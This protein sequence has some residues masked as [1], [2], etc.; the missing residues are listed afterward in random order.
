MP[1]RIFKFRENI[2]LRIFSSKVFV[3]KLLRVLSF[4]VF[5]AVIASGVYFYGFPQTEHS[6][7]FDQRIIKYSLI[8]FSVRFLIYVFYDFHPVDFIKNNRVEGI[9]LL[10][11]VIYML[12]PGFFNSLIFKS[13]FNDITERHSHI[14]FQIYF[15]SI[16]VV[17]LGKSGPKFSALNLSPASALILSFIILIGAGAGLLMLPEMTTAG[18]ISFINALFTSTSASC[19][20]GLIVV[21]TA[22]FFTFKGKLIIMLLIQLGGI[23]IISFATFFVTFSRAH[24]NIK[25][26]SFIKDF[27]SADRLSDTK[28]LLR[29]IVLFSL[30]SEGI[31]TAL[32]FFSWGNV[33][34]GSWKAQFFHS[35]FHAVSAFNNAGFSTFTNNLYQ[36]GIRDLYAVQVVVILLIFFGG[37]GFMSMEDIFSWSR[38][39]ERRKMPWKRLNIST[40]VTLYMSLFLIAFGAIIF[41]LVERNTHIYGS[42]NAFQIGITSVFQ[43]V[44]TRTAGFNTVDISALKAPVLILF[45]FLMFVGAGSGSTGGGIK[46]TTFAVIVKSAL[47]TIKGEKHV[48]FFKRTVPFSAI[49]RAYSIA[50]FSITV[51]FVSA[52]LLSITEPHTQFLKLLFEEFSAFGTVGLSTGITPY[53]SSAGKVIIVL[54]MFIGRIGSLTLAMAL[55]TRAISTNYKY[56][57]SSIIVG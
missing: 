45:I 14:L 57:E 9:V 42:E 32:L 15:L 46:V 41:Y 7:L 8:F 54:S 37:F 39:K 49:D 11:F 48:V 1:S 56:A 27:L 16:F 31:G 38:I 35:A 50:L 21:D 55:S 43:S 40:K 3:I 33:Q 36:N 51:I 17:E 30:L 24:G 20:T 23:N 10:L 52:F 44:T 29:S 2:N 13:L 5:T 25:Y 34:F 12:M 26:Q 6:L 22:T 18:H 28:H 4:F 47:A 19:V 53:L